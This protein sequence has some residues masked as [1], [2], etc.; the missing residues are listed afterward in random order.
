ME[1]IEYKTLLYPPL[2]GQID[3]MPNNIYVQGNVE[4]LGGPKLVAIVGSRTID[5]YARV[6]IEKIVWSVVGQKWVTVSGLALGVDTL[7]AQMTLKAKGKTIAVIPGGVDRARP[8]ANQLI[9]EQIL[10]G[11][12]AIVSEDKE[13]AVVTRESFLRRNRIVA[14]MCQGIVVVSGKRRSGTLNTAAWA[15][16]FGREVMAVPGR[17]TDELQAAPNWLIK[18]GAAVVENGADVLEILNI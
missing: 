15:A 5:D 17:A 9:F 12:G 8:K 7:V 11:G 13:G 1:I 14:G 3:E 18:N 6:M 2:L 4:L 16:R 10:A